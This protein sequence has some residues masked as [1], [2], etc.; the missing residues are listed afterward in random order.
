[1]K[2][3]EWRELTGHNLHGANLRAL[4]VLCGE[5]YCAF[6]QRDSQ[7]ALALSTSIGRFAIAGSV[8]SKNSQ[9]FA[10]CLSGT[11]SA[12]GSEHLFTEYSS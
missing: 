12:A 10:F 8:Y 6:F 1:M 9:K 2:I 3:L 7:Y 5:F 4:C 11:Q